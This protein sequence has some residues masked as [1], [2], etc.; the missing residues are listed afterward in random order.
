MKYVV[1]GTCT[2]SV[3][4]YYSWPWTLTCYHV[5][6]YTPDIAEEGAS[7]EDLLVTG[8]QPIDHH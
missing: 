8:N 6:I 2:I 4:M 3:D 7:L 1:V 5:T